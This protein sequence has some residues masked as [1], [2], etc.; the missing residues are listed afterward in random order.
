VN[1]L[2]GG[3]LSIYLDGAYNNCC[4]T[5]P[6]TEVIDFALSPQVILGSETPLKVVLASSKIEPSND[7]FSAFYSQPIEVNAEN[8]SLINQQGFTVLKGNDDANDLI[9]PGATVITGGLSVPV[10]FS[11]SLNDTRLTVTPSNTL[12]AGESYK[13]DINAITNKESQEIDNITNDELSFSV[14]YDLDDVFTIEDIKLDNEN[15]TTNG[16]AI[17]VSNTAGEAANPTN[18]YNNVSLYLPNSINSLQNL[19]LRQVSY[20][21]NNI[22]SVAI[23]TYQVVVN[24]D[25][26]PQAVGIVN[27]AHNE[28]YAPENNHRS[29]VVSSAQTETQKVYR[30]YTWEYFADNTNIETNTISFE[31]SFETKAGEV[32]TGNITIP[33]Q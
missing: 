8:I 4:F 26:S 21:K 32:V 23:E 3:N 12:I 31:Y 18:S 16:S 15:F 27:L 10:T 5:I 30:R 7:S 24:G 6:N 25:V 13:Y 33:V 2:T 9:L 20:V 14:D 22:S 11:L 17:T 29:I 28:I 19:T 1:K